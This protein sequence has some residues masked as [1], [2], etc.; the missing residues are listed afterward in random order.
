MFYLK[1]SL[2][3]QF[4]ASA[5]ERP[6]PRRRRALGVP[7][8]FVAELVLHLFLDSLLLALVLG[9]GAY[10]VLEALEFDRHLSVLPLDLVVLH[11]VRA[12]LETFLRHLEEDAGT[13]E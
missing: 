1:K 5:S 2:L 13:Q 12:S 9:H 10:D 11:D 4:V 7:I 6:P 3:T 8:L